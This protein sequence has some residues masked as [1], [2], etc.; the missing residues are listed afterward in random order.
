MA[1]VSWPQSSKPRRCKV[2]ALRA[3][4]ISASLGRSLWGWGAAAASIFFLRRWEMWA[5]ST[6]ADQ[7]HKT[8]LHHARWVIF[9]SKGGGGYPVHFC[10]ALGFLEH[11]R[12]FLP[13][14]LATVSRAVFLEDA[15][16][17]MPWRLFFYLKRR[18]IK[19]EIRAWKIFQGL[20][21]GLLCL[22]SSLW[23]SEI[24]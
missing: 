5:T 2:L 12:L 20:F 10:L 18:Y 22:A 13:L 16:N 21:G 19:L 15:R 9:W 4:Y 3:Q 6:I 11:L 8:F 1:L 24:N 17:E 7:I 14:L 23:F